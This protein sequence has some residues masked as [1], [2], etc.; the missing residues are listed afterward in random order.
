MKEQAVSW[1]KKF[2]RSRKVIMVGKISSKYE[3]L[4]V[5]EREISIIGIKTRIILDMTPW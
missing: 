3:I 5:E 4:T 2:G 1:F